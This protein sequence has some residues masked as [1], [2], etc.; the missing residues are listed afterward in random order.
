M[1]KPLV[2][3][4]LWSMLQPLIPPRKPR[5]KKGDSVNAIALSCFGLFFQGFSQYLAR[6][7]HPSVRV[8]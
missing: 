1:A 7:G 5:S 8:L 4:E 2:C 6:L 3:D